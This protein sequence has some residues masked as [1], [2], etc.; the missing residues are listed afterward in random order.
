MTI[1][2]S[3]IVWTVISFLI[4]MLILHNLLFKPVLS[5]MD[6]RRARIEKAAAKKAEEERLLEEHK[7]VQQEKKEAYLKEQ[8]AKLKEESEKIQTES[9][10]AIVEARHARLSEVDEYRARM[11]QE[12]QAILSAV[13]PQSKSFAA[14][15]ASRIISK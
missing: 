10:K 15:F 13:G 14:L 11:E 8:K 1:Q 2:V 7:K 3:I 12:Q 6:K 4:L 9:K 5:V